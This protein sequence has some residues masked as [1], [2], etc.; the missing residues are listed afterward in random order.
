[1]QSSPAFYKSM[2]RL[3]PSDL[4][5]LSLTALADIARNRQD[6]SASN[7]ARRDYQFHGGVQAGTSCREREVCLVGPAGSGK[8]RGWLERMH[9]DALDHPKS[10]QLV[11][12]ATRT[13][14]TSSAMVT[15]RDEVFP[16]GTFGDADTD[17]PIRFHSG[18]QAYLYPNGA[19]IG[20]VGLD[21]PGKVFSSQWDRIYCQEVNELAERTRTHQS[22]V[23][24]ATQRLVD[25][26]LV[27]RQIDPT[28]ARRTA[29]SLTPDARRLLVNTPDAPTERLID[30]LRRMPD[31]E[32]A[33]LAR[34][35][36]RLVKDLGAA[37]GPATMLFEEDTAQ[38]PPG[39]SV[40][41]RK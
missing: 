20:V 3:T 36:N 12:R 23:S 17:R 27:L 21:D 1:M 41:A 4:S 29:L 31:G 22:S 16:E 8:S 15:L 13:S 30:A 19:R 32:R 2:S 39:K 26:G 9:R 10:R 14:L 25:R 11:V 38:T 24:V 28:D 33:R 37:D 7:L 5:S 34:S 35:L 6:S 18:E 40:N